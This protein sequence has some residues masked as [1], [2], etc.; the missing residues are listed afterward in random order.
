MSNEYDAVRMQLYGL[1]K[2]AKEGKCQEPKPKP[3]T[4]LGGEK[5][6]TKWE[7]WMK[8]STFSK[9]EAMARY[10]S[11]ALSVVKSRGGGAGRRRRQSQESGDGGE[12]GSGGWGCQGGEGR[13]CGRR[14]RCP[15][16]GD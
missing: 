6:R 16:A 5:N 3:D 9:E 13:G 1:Y 12:S 8:A 15:D 7:A 11:V 10:V 14:G 4:V 2:V